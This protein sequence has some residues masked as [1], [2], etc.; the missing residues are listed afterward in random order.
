MVPIVALWLPI[1]ASA[2]IVFIVSS[3]L[4]MVLPYHRTDYGKLSHEDDVMQAMRKA[5]VAPGDYLM[6]HCSSPSAMKDPAFVEK[7]TK[8]PVAMMTIMPSGP[9]SMGGQLAQWFVYCVVVSIFAAYIS[10]RALQPGAPYRAV[11]RFAGAT[12]FIGYALA[13]WQDSIWYKKAWSTTIKNTI[14]GLIYGCLTA[15]TFGWLWPR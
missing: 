15:G 9:P 8:G 10:G 6:P 3:L 5:G 14:D 11:F 13:L 4:H 1:L 12:A 2:V 7:M